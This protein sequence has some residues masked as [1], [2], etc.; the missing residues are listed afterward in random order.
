MSQG[1]VKVEG[2]PV[3]DPKAEV[4]TGGDEPVLIQVGKRRFA[5]IHFAN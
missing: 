1:G 3:V 5:R 4:A 2:E